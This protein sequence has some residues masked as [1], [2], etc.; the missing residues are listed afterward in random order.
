MRKIKKMNQISRN[1]ILITLA[2][3]MS[4]QCSTNN[5]SATDKQPLKVDFDF[6]GRKFGEIHHEE[7]ESWL[8]EE[9][10]EIEKNFDG[11]NIKLEGDFSSSWYKAGTQKHEDGKLI[12]DGIKAND[13]LKFTISGLEEGE[14]SLLTFHNTFDNPESKTYVPVNIYVNNELVETVEPGAR[15]LETRKAAMAY[16]TFEVEKNEDVTIKYEVD[17]D[18]GEENNQLVLNGFELDL[19]NRMKQ[20]SK[21]GP[22]NNDEHVETD[23]GLSL[24]WRVPEGTTSSEVYFGEDQDAVANATK[25]DDEYKGELNDKTYDPDDLYS[26]NTYYWRV[27]LIDENGK[28]TKGTVWSFRPAQLAFPGAEGYGRYAIGGRGGK[29]VEV[30]NLN[31]SGPGSLREAVTKDIGPRTVV[32]TVSGNIELESRLVVNQPYIT[33]AGQTAPGKGITISRA[34]IG[35]TGDDGI[36]R[37]LRVRIGAGRTYDGMGLTGADHSIIDHSSISWTL[38]EGFS[39][40]GAQN[41][42]LQRTLIS[43]ALNIA[44]HG[45]YEEG[46]MHGYAA[47]IGGDTGSFHHNLLAHNYG[48]NWS[49]AGG[50]DGNGYYTGRLD[51]R[52]NVVYNWGHRATDGGANKVNFV[53]NYYKP[54]PSTDFFYALNAQHEGVGKGKQQYFFDENIMTG[55]FD[56]STQEEGRTISLSGEAQ[57]DY[58]TYVDEPFFEPHVTTHSPEEAYK[59]VLSDVGTNQPELDKHDRRIIQ[60]TL[61]STYSNVGSKSGLP[62]MIDT[63]EDSGSWEDYPEE[64]RSEDWDSDHDG[65]PDWWEEAKDLNP[66]SEEGDFAD[67]NLDEDRDGFTQLDNYLDWM[68]KPHYIIDSGEEINFSA[69]ELFRGFEDNPEY[70]L[71]KVENLEAS[72]EKGEL[73]FATKESG[74]AE[75]TLSVEDAAGHTMEREVMVFVK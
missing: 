1:C 11:V 69:K 60:E 4:I 71:N 35:L 31:D 40:R 24:T 53:G 73:S 51:I 70:S 2:A 66:N 59:N 52:N 54:G 32:F 62:G 29:V 34:P 46:K 27:D 20:A 42:T 45:K 9:G 16:I 44:N 55:Y 75:L 19:P 67:A 5:S 15:E 43:E 3:F 30:T 49:L 50:V 6:S 36:I 25:D 28:T 64:E 37:F 61:D 14:H 65:L 17:K 22:A 68:S 18:S 56:E 7:Y 39:S 48:R 38:D 12:A 41:I 33:I 47:S 72:L 58:E 26:M 74:F 63:E 13:S 21:P 23:K 57:V 8:I 10:S